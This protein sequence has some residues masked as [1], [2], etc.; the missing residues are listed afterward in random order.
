MTPAGSD[1][2]GLVREAVRSSQDGYLAHIVRHETKARSKLHKRL[3]IGSQD[4]FLRATRTIGMKHPV[5]YLPKSCSTQLLNVISS[6][7]PAK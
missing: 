5:E 1:R 7:N 4:L 2:V 3:F 6:K